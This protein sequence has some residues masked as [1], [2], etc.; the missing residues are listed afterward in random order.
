MLTK[1]PLIAIVAIWMSSIASAEVISADHVS[2][3][4]NA[5]TRDTVQGLDF[6][7]L[8]HSTALSYNDVSSRFGEGED[9]AGFRYASE[10]EVVALINNWGFS[11]GVSGIDVDGGGGVVGDTGGDQLSGLVDLLGVNYMILGPNI[12]TSLGMTG[13]L[14]VGTIRTLSREVSVNNRPSGDD[15]VG[16]GA[17]EVGTVNNST[18]S[19]LV[20]ESVPEPASIMMLAFGAGMLGIGWLRRRR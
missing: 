1:V 12:A 6:L 7:D 5:I 16:Y 3:G 11:P 17:L 19:W 20:Q 18:G 14:N 2:F 13:T 8:A 4:L 15:Y 10:A 9:F